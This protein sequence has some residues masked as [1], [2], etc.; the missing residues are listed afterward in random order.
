MSIENLLRGERG[1]SDEESKSLWIEA[2]QER[3]DFLT[4]WTTLSATDFQILQTKKT[5]LPSMFCALWKKFHIKLSDD[6]N[7]TTSCHYLGVIFPSLIPTWCSKFSGQFP[8]LLWDQPRLLVS[9]GGGMVLEWAADQCPLPQQSFVALRLWEI[10]CCWPH[11][12][13]KEFFDFPTS[14]YL[15]FDCQLKSG[16]LSLTSAMALNS[17]SP[18]KGRHAF[19]TVHSTSNCP[20]W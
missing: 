16:F 13:P 14:I 15:F 11:S 10:L 6:M 19:L 2:M 20:S 4:S 17:R 12:I 9:V 8:W 18:W 1:V 7:L 3:F 5:P